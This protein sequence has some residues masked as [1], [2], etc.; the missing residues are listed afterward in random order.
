MAGHCTSLRLYFHD[1]KA[2]ENTVQDCNIQPYCL[3]TH[4]IIDLLYITNQQHLEDRYCA[5]AAQKSLLHAYFNKL[6]AVGQFL[7]LYGTSMC[8]NLSTSG[9]KYCKL[10]NNAVF[11]RNES[12]FIVSA[13]AT[14]AV[15]LMHMPRLL[16]SI[17]AAG[18]QILTIEYGKILVML[19]Y[20]KYCW[21]IYQVY[22]KV[23]YSM[24][25]TDSLVSWILSWSK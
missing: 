5:C 25:V 7:A 14:N 3:H 22:N 24:Y 8:I 9:G 6:Q 21:C 2:S 11:I 12:L 19:L 16:R 10:V 1:M 13:A 15:Q 23:W 20:G 4:Q 17:C 18:Y